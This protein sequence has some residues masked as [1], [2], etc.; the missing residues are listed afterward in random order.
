[1]WCLLTE[2]SWWLQSKNDLALLLSSSICNSLNTLFFL[3]T[4]NFHFSLLTFIFQNCTHTLWFSH[5]T[6]TK[7]HTHLVM[8]NI[9]VKFILTSNGTKMILALVTVS[10]YYVKDSTPTWYMAPQSCFPYFK[11][12][13]DFHQIGTRTY[14][15]PWVANSWFFALTRIQQ[16]F[17]PLQAQKYFHL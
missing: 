9:K 17:V 12:C 15:F 8:L 2:T 1:V 16:K 5:H 6:G 4:F 7:N 10:F 3:H 11:M 13:C 14:L